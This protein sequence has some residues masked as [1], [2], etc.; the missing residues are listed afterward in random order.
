MNKCTFALKNCIVALALLLVGL[1]PPA[2]QAAIPDG[3]KVLPLPDQVE[4]AEKPAIKVRYPKGLDMMYSVARL[5]VNDREVSANCVRTP[6]YISYQPFKEMMP[7][8]VNVRFEGKTLA[9]KQEVKFAWSFELKGTQPI[10][11]ITH[12]CDHDMFY[13]EQV[14]VQ[15]ETTPG[16][17]VWFGL[18]GVTDHVPMVED[19]PGKYEGRYT[20]KMSDNKLKSHITVYLKQGI[21]EYSRTLDKTVS[22]CGNMFAIIIDEP[23][24]NEQVPLQFKIKGHTR[25]HATIYMQPRIGLG[26]VSAPSNDRGA[27]SLGSIPCYADENGKFELEYGFPIK[28]PNMQAS[29]IFTGT[30]REGNMAMIK[31]LWVNFK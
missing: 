8:P 11:S 17:Q 1:C 22:I 31:Q 6:R 14:V 21:R 28:L 3:Y 30:D 7:G 18:E 20:V 10:K 24:Q 12:N 23:K 2:A 25:P 9:K 4:T 27:A 29:L 26:G 5:W 15:A 19:L 13:L 16:A